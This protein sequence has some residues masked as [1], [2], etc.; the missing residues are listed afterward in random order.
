[1]QQL[2]SAQTQFFQTPVL[3]QI[4]NRVKEAGGINLGQG[5]CSLAPPSDL[6]EAAAR[7]MKDGVNLYTDPRGLQSL[8]EA[9]AVKLYRDNQLLAD[10]DSG[11][12]VTCG[13]TGA[14]ESVCGVLLNPGDKVVVFEPSYPY[15]IQALNRYQADVITIPL[16]GESWNVD[17]DLVADALKQKPKFILVNTPGN[18]TGK[19]WSIS[20]L[21]ALSSLMEH[22][23]TLLVTDEIY[24][25]MVFDGE[26][27]ISPGSLEGLKNKTITIGGFSKTFSITGWRLGFL[28][29]PA[30]LTKH[31]VRFLDAVYVCPPA[32]LQQGTADMLDSFGEE[33]L[34]KIAG[35]YQAKRDLF[36]QGLME[37]GFEP[38]PLKGA[39]Y[40]LASW[41]ESLKCS[42]SIQAAHALI[43]LSGVGAV[44]SS[45]F[46]RDFSA[47]PWLRFCLAH[48]DSV[49]HDALARLEAAFA[50]L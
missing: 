5:V 4:T 21:N 1:M 41:P 2:L 17:F 8:R 33:Y 25:Y 31:F 34:P 29:L 26:K 45:D 13:A 43:D 15:H 11:V 37:L 35:K 39:Y 47:Y 10:P 38:L 12:V 27:H 18:P 16:N 24:E 44:P 19:V 42:T 49:L 3:R 7:A 28:H 32:P 23:E 20:E 50:R 6:I 9:I 40:L 14:F 48:E 36:S 30:E 22:S 46:V